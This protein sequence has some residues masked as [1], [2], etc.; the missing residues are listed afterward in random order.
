MKVW[1]TSSTPLE[2]RGRLI[3]P[4]DGLEFTIDFIPDRDLKLQ[5]DKLLSFGEELPLWYTL[6]KSVSYTSPPT[7]A[8]AE[9]VATTPVE[10]VARKKQ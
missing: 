4:G 9:P 6:Q 8:A 7:P 1:N 3:T 5:K 10:P 2:Y